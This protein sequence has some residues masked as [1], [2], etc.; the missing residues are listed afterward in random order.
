MNS[1]NWSAP[2]NWVFIAR[3]TEHW[4]AKA[5]A[6]VSNPLEALKIFFG[7]NFAIA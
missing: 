6:V 4:G 5:E 3:S 2:N 1:I 7:L